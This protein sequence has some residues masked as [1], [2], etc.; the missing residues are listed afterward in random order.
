[1]TA[2]KAVRRYSADE[3]RAAAGFAIALLHHSMGHDR[4]IGHSILP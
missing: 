1:M 4:W 2:R 3:K